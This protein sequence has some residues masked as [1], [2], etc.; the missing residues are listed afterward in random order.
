[1]YIYIYTISFSKK[2]KQ[3]KK[4]PFAIFAEIIKYKNF[5]VYKKKKKYFL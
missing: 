3:V 4:K 1:M 5:E 2:K